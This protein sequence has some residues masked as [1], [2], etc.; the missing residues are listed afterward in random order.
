[1]IGKTEGEG[2][3]EQQVNKTQL[4]WN[5]WNWTLARMFTELPCPYMAKR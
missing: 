2:T 4:H 3:H 1:M 5:E